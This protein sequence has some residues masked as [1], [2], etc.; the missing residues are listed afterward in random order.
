ME[1]MAAAGGCPFSGPRKKED[2]CP[3]GEKVVAGHGAR[4]HLKIMHLIHPQV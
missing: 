1:A 2:V 4:E 3:A